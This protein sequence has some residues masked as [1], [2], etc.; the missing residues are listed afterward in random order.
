M[1][2]GS[3]VHVENQTGFAQYANAQDSWYSA[4]FQ[5]QAD[6]SPVLGPSDHDGAHEKMQ[7][8]IRM[9]AAG[10]RFFSVDLKTLGNGAYFKLLDLQG[11]TVFQSRVTASQNSI[12]LSAVRTGVYLVSVSNGYG[13]STQKILI[14]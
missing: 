4:Q 6:A 8:T 7:F 5:F 3:I 11:R 10:K 9:N 2:T 12:D 14:K 13:V 1:Q